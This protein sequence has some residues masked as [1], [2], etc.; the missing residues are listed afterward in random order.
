MGTLRVIRGGSYYL[1]EA[2]VRPACRIWYGPT[3]F[4]SNIGFRVAR[5]CPPPKAAP[6]ASPSE[7]A[8]TR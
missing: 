3:S 2:V 4:S 7:S 6:K 5:D 1:D 8:V